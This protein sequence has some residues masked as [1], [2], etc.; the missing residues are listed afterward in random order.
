MHRFMIGALAALVVFPALAQ[1]PTDTS[2]IGGGKGWDA[3]AYTEKGAKV[4]YLVG[5]PESSL[6]KGLGRGR[7]DAYITHR[8]ADKA[9]NVVH[10]DMGYPF[11]PGAT[12]DLDIDGHKFSLFTDKEAAWTNDAAE[13]KAVTEALNKGKRATL[14]GSS[15]RG[16]ATTDVYALDGFKDALASIDKSCGVKR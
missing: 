5:T 8:P 16:T 7:I 12:A 13:D 3:F 1:T 6:P 10:F 15:A 11:K 2:R 14:K 4:C 9:W